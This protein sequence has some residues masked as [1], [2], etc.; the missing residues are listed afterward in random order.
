[1][2]NTPAGS[3][4]QRLPQ[5]VH[6]AAPSTQPRIGTGKRGREKPRGGHTTPPTQDKPTAKIPPPA[7]APGQSQDRGEA[8]PFLLRHSSSE[9]RDGDSARVAIPG[10]ASTRA[11]RASPAHLCFNPPRNQHRRRSGS[12]QAALSRGTVGILSSETEHL[13]GC[14]GPATFPFQ[15]Q[16]VPLR[17][18]E[19]LIIIVTDNN[20]H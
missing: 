7:A 5:S 8:E 17:R 20:C 14:Q 9:R 12:T 6:T 19:S 18:P 2:K 16:A 15:I 11:L 13:R 10:T 1:M 3:G 4:Q